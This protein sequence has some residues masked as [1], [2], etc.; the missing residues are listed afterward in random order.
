MSARHQC[1]HSQAPCTV[2]EQYY[3]L[4]DITFCLIAHGVWTQVFRKWWRRKYSLYCLSISDDFPFRPY[5]IFALQCYFLASVAAYPM[6]RVSRN[7]ESGFVVTMTDKTKKRVE[8][9]CTFVTIF[10]IKCDRQPEVTSFLAGMDKEYCIFYSKTLCAFVIFLKT[11][12]LPKIFRVHC[13]YIFSQL[14]CIHCC[15][16]RIWRRLYWLGLPSSRKNLWN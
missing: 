6:S 1:K 14:E 9:V 4:A 7:V 15:M 11:V 13:A 8:G 5:K 16:P 2:T 10:N 3:F 12:D